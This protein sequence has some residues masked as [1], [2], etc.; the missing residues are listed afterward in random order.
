MTTATHK[1][2]TTA[3]ATS[4]SDF[5]QDLDGG[6]FESKL[7]IALSQVAAATVDHEKSGKVWKSQHRNDF[8]THPRHWPS[9]L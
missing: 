2:D 8:P 7:S 3:A 4:V 5:I 6:M 1:P 9:A